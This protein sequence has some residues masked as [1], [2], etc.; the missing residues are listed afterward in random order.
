MDRKTP[1]SNIS[2][3][4]ASWQ[5]ERKKLINTL[6]RFGGNQ[7]ETARAL[8]VSRVTIWKRVKKYKIDLAAELAKNAAS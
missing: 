7:S 4:P 3:S 6:H 8:G 2:S 5:E 1:S